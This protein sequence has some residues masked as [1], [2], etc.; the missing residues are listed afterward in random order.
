MRQIGRYGAWILLTARFPLSCASD[1]HSMSRHRRTRKAIT[2]TVWYHTP[3]RVVTS[4]GDDPRAPYPG[5]G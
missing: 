4:I 3:T 1:G 2:K 5:L